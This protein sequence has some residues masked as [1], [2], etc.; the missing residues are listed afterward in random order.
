MIRLAVL[1]D[2]PEVVRMSDAFYKTTSYHTLS[3]I[4]IN[5][6]TVASLAE[7][8]IQDETLYVAELAKK[9]CGMLAMISV[10]FIFNTDYRHLAEIA[11]WVDEEAKGAGV[12]KLLLKQAELVGISVGAA[13][14]QMADLISSGDLPGKI[15]LKEGY[16]LTERLWTKVL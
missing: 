15:Y 4:P 7:S 8:L 12:G 16:I 2:I 9:V 5:Y 11:W 13:H 14:V 1:E 10:P 3:K 6:D